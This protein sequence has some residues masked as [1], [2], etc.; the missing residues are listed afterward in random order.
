MIWTFNSTKKITRS[1][2][3]IPEFKKQIPRFS[4]IAHI[5]KCLPVDGL[6]V[7]DIKSPQIGPNVHHTDEKLKIKEETNRQT[8]RI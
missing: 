1:Q 8:D 3:T 6:K 7:D 4:V 2:K 5:S